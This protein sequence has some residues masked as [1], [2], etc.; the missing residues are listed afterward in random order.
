MEVEKIWTKVTPKSNKSTM[1]D[2]ADILNV[3]KKAELTDGEQ[4]EK[5]MSG[6]AAAPRPK[7]IKK[8]KGMSREVFDLV[9]PGGLPI[10]N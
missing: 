8:P 7:K 6:A 5:I 3:K 4:T 2:I 9:G 1:G 10:G